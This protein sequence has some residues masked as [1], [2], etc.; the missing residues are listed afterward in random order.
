MISKISAPGS[1]FLFVSSASAQL[2]PDNEAGIEGVF[3]GQNSLLIGVLV[4]LLLVL[5]LQKFRSSKGLSRGVE[6]LSERR[7]GGPDL[8][9]LKP[10]ITGSGTS[11]EDSE[12]VRES[13]LECNVCGAEF[14]SEEEKTLHEDALH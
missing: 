9:S 2:I 11:D 13:D 8:E 1:V 4:F 3:Q 6:T 7:G 10:S 14:D 5:F 12:D